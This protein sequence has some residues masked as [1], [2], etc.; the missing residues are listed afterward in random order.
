MSLRAGWPE[1]S[2]SR[3]RPSLIVVGSRIRH[4]EHRWDGP[5]TSRPLPVD[6]VV[7]D[8]LAQR[9]RL[10]DEFQ[11]HLYLAIDAAIAGDLEALLISRWM[12]QTLYESRRG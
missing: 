11:A 8:P 2:Y 10:M 1:K 7:V 4:R 6:R 3:C 9:I 12:L 5:P